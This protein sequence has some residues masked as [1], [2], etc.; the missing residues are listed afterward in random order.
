VLVNT[1]N[2]YFALENAAMLKLKD[3]IKAILA[4]DA[5]CTRGNFDLDQEKF[6]TTYVN[7]KITLATGTLTMKVPIFDLIYYKD[8]STKVDELQYSIADIVDW[9]T[10]EFVE[11]GTTMAMGRQF[12][13]NTYVT[14]AAKGVERTISIGQLSDMGKITSS[15]RLWLMLFGCF[16]VLLILLALLVKLCKKKG[17][18]KGDNY[19]AVQNS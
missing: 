8:E 15:E 2:E 1:G 19:Q 14:F 3:Q 13:I 12:L 4:C 9:Q 18:E 5:Q 16:I 10:A 7:M 17:G 11:A 6:H